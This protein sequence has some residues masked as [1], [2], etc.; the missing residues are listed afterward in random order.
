MTKTLIIIPAYNEEK[1]ILKVLQ[2]VKEDLVGADI[3]VID[4]CSKDRTREVVQNVKGVNLISLPVNLG[5]S[6]ALQ[7][8]FKFAVENSY[9][10]VIQFDGDGQ[11][12]ASEA[13]ALINVLIE[14]NA[15]IVIG[16]RFKKENDYNHSFFRKMGTNFFKVIIRSVCKVDITDPTSGFQVLRKS[17]FQNYA[18]MNNYPEYPDANLII[19]MLLRGFRVS[20]YQVR[21]RNREF[22]ESM[23]SGII[24]PVKYMIKMFY[25]IVFVL[26]KSQR[27]SKDN[28]KFKESVR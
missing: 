4:D 1:N 27:L 18:L 22:G 11:H 14:E 16:S 6:G 21:M 2:E 5:Y 28:N 24:K 25:A 23:H 3:L 10:I 26:L 20:E 17:V 13:K 9:D 12:I 7:T 15:D 19:D 8:G